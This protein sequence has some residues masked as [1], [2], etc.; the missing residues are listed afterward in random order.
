MTRGTYRT[1]A[2]LAIL[3][4]LAA[5]SFAGKKD[6]GMTIDI[7]NAD[8]ENISIAIS[9]NLVDGIIYSILGDTDLE[10][11][12]DLSVEKLLSALDTGLPALGD[13]DGVSGADWEYRTFRLSDPFS[14]LPRAFMNSTVTTAP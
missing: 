4:T 14:D 7:E 13:Y 6:K 5:P 3:L 9:S 8:G 11:P 2:A 1:I 12:W 10:D